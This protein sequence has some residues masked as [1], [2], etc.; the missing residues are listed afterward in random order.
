MK[1]APMTVRPKFDLMKQSDILLFYHIQIPRW[2][3]YDSR[4]KHISNDAKLLYGLLLNRFQLSKMNGWINDNGEIFIIYTRKSVSEQL[5]VSNKKAISC[6]RELTEVCLIWERRCGRGDANQIYLAHI[7]HNEEAALKHN[8]APFVSADDETVAGFRSAVSTHQNSA[9]AQE[10]YSLLSDLAADDVAV[11]SE[12]STPLGAQEMPFSQLK[13]TRND[14]SRNAETAAQDMSK[15][16]PS[17]TDKSYTEKSYSEN[18]QSI[19][20]ARGHEGTD[21]TAEDLDGLSRVLHGC[22]LWI[23]S[24]EMAKV[25]ENAIERLWFTRSYRIGDAVLPQKKVRSHL[26]ELDNIRLQEAERKLAANLDKRIKNS[27]AYVMAVI[28]NS[29]WECESDL[30]VDPYLNRLKHSETEEKHEF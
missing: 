12:K 14:M 5:G 18:S 9:V 21:G 4:Y 10:D 22:D 6:M 8:S 23:F 1:A 25:F 13:K 15:M 16:H 19:S 17:Y 2:L 7:E 24:H 26:Y 11:R 29:I 30:L 28:F 20:P 27:T 3:F